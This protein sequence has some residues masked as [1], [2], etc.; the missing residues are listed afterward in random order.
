MTDAE[1]REAIQYHLD[2]IDK[3]E[4]YFIDPETEEFVRKKIDYHAVEIMRLSN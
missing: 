4:A 2:C 1:R 3:L